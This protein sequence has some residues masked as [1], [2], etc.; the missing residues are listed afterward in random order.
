MLGFKRRTTVA[1]TITPDAD[2]AEVRTLAESA[3]AKATR[4]LTLAS[5]PKGRLAEQTQV[6]QYEALRGRNFVPYAR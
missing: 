2:L 1:I 5:D 4:A 6:E 3:L